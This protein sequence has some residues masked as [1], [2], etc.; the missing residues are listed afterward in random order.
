VLTVDKHVVLRRVWCAVDAGL[1]INPDGAANQIEGGVIQAASWTL[2]EAV[3]I[4][5][6]AIAT[7]DWENYP[8]L[9]CS[10]PARP[11]S[12][13]H[14]VCTRAGIAERFGPRLT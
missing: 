4:A 7:L 11:R 9:R 1:V 12:R 8:I 6:G 3:R 14:A 13:A 2:K 5:D 10:T